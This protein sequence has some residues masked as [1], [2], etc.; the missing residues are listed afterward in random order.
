LLHQAAQVADVNSD[1]LAEQLAWNPSQVCSM[2]GVNEP[3]RRPTLS[4]VQ[5]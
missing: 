5:P 1:D 2:L 3:D 4:L